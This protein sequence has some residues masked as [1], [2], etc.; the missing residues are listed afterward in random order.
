MEAISQRWLKGRSEMG[1]SMGRFDPYEKSEQLYALALDEANRVHAF[2]SFIPISGRG[3]WGLDLMRRAEQCAPGTMELLLARSIEHIKSCGG[4]MVSLGLAP[5]SNANQEDE[6]FLETSIDSLT[7]RFGN[8]ARNQ[9]LFNFKKKFHPKWESRYLVYSDALNLPKIGWAVYHAHHHGASM[10]GALRR[11]L[12]ERR[13]RQ[14]CDQ[15][16]TGALETLH[17]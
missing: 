2:V 7:Y 17:I 11:S 13:L 1:F 4:K 3:G 10:L 8:P 14:E 5:L 16:R 15:T 12:E 9:S 6:N